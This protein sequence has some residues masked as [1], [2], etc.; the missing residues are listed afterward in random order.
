M[1]RRPPYLCER[2]WEPTL[3]VLRLVDGVPT[4]VSRCCSAYLIALR[5]APTPREFLRRRRQRTT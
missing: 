2:C 5:N 1:K 3:P 4:P